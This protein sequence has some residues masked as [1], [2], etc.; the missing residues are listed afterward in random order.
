MEQIT[1]RFHTV[2][3]EV[4]A[5]ALQRPGGRHNEDRIRAISRAAEDG[6]PLDPS[7]VALY[8]DLKRIRDLATHL[9][10]DGQPLITATTGA[11]SAVIGLHRKLIG[12]LPTMQRLCGEVTTITPDASL[13][14]ASR[15]MRKMDYS[16][17]PVITDDGIHGLL[18]GNDIVWWLGGHLDDIV[19]LEEMP[20]SEVMHAHPAIDY[21]IV[22]RDFKQ[23]DVPGLFID[24]GPTGC[25]VGAVLITS[26]GHAHERILG[27]ITPW[28]LPSMNGW[29]DG[30]CP[31]VG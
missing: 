25:P 27:I 15:L 26:T 2:F 29:H 23:R 8:E 12:T 20:V 9:R 19:L 16:T 6:G 3:E 31:Q 24:R 30:A 28:D 17:L 1:M 13:A 5:A 7:D 10:E 4:T 22:G 11:L 14:D 21:H 18:T